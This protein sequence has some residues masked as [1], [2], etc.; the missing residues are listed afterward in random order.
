MPARKDRDVDAERPEGQPTRE[1]E[2]DRSIH[3]VVAE[4]DP[5]AGAF[6]GVDMGGSDPSLSGVL[7]GSLGASTAGGAGGRAGGTGGGGGAG[8]AGGAAT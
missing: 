7:G 4:Y 3:P 5:A 1:P 6:R 2:P 8:G